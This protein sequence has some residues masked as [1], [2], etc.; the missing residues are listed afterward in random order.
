MF[1]LRNVLSYGLR[2][3]Q[4]VCLCILKQMCLLQR[5]NSRV[6]SA[7]G[8]WAHGSPLPATPRPT[9][10]SSGVSYGSAMGLWCLAGDV[11]SAD[12]KSSRVEGEASRERCVVALIWSAVLVT[13]NQGLPVQRGV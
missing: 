3:R 5:L 6:E 7:R 9:P 8:D 13:A 11:E 1:V 4:F 2:F 10:L 12:G